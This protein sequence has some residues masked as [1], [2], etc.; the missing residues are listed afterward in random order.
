MRYYRNIRNLIED[1]DFTVEEL[2]EL[3]SGDV[4]DISSNNYRM[5]S[6][7]VILDIM[8]EELESDPY[9][10]GCFNADFIA[11]NTNLSYD[12]VKALQ[13]GEQF[14]ALGNHIIANSYT[15]EMAEEYARLNGYGHHFAHYDGSGEELNI[16]GR[17]YH[18]FRTH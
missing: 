5:I 4:D 9:I 18:L 12:I 6:D 10:L 11:D 3:F 8:I 16:M 13:D 2:R 1:N 14:E 17:D 7:D 15:E